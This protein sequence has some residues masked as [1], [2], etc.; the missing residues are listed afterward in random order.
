MFFLEELEGLG[1]TCHR[2]AILFQHSLEGRQS[3]IALLQFMELITV[4]L[5]G[6]FADLF[7]ADPLGLLALDQLELMISLSRKSSSR[8]RLNL[9]FSSSRLNICSSNVASC[10]FAAAVFRIL[11]LGG[12]FVGLRRGFVRA[13][14]FP[15]ANLRVPRQAVAGFRPIGQLDS[16]G[17]LVLRPNRFPPEL[18]VAVGAEVEWQSG[19]VPPCDVPG[20]PTMTQSV[21]SGGL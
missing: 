19:P 10:S 6:L 11:V 8:S 2:L 14:L 13:L 7:K 17:F 3:F 21:L 1:L 18:R 20:R 5:L 9:A 12:Q 4:I 15:D 16:P